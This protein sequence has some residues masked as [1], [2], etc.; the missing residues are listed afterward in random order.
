MPQLGKPVF[1]SMPWTDDQARAEAACHISTLSSGG[2]QQLLHL[3]STVQDLPEPIQAGLGVL[4]TAALLLKAICARRSG[5][6]LK[7]GVI[8]SIMHQHPAKTVVQCM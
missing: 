1:P 3:N 4:H 8:D 6:L 5:H 7:I 2:W